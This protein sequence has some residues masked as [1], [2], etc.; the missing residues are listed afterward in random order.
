MYSKACAIALTLVLPATASP[1]VEGLG[2]R[3][4][5]QK[6][7][8]LADSRGIFDYA[9][10]VRQVVHDHNKHRS[11]LQNV[12]R[13]VGRDAF[14][15]GA[16]IKSLMELP[17][18]ALERRQSEGLND[19]DHDEFWAGNIAV[20]TPA[21]PFYIDFDTGSSDLW[22]PS[23]KCTQS[24]CSN[25]HK[26]NLSVSSTGKQTDRQFS[27]H[28][29][30]GSA[31]SGP[32]FTDTVGFA[33]LTVKDQY[34][35]A[36]T[37][38]SDSFGSQAN[39]GILGLGYPLLSN[40][41]KPPFVNSAKAQGVIRQAAFGFKLSKVGSELYIGGTDK[42]QYTGDVEYHNVVGNTGYW[43]IGGGQ[44]TIGSKI[45]STGIKTVIDSGTT[46]IYGPP[47][48]VAKLY[49]SI[50]GSSMHGAN[51]GFYSFPCDKVPSN[52]AFSWGGKQWTI[53]AENFNAGQKS[54]LEFTCLGAI[55]A[56]DLGL[57]DNVWLVG[58][59]FMKNVY[60]AFSF[61]NNAVGFAT[62]K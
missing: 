17:T 3:V 6:R 20:G 38:L 46:L 57:G 12:E 48:A 2:I 59:S 28:Y 15:E 30:D 47:D 27:I 34:F 24:A 10:A 35:S 32:V 16:D 52:V 41:Q 43:Q 33:G 60:S 19:E 44:L 40:I 13:H 4:P 54:L 39:D 62:L 31:V 11:N 42:T 7:S 51:T 29:G 36:A 21:Q 1:V 45:V 22:F 56:K 26:Y 9:K 5:F 50:P 18:H 23:T 61:E 14:N 8:A 49:A 25:K 55:V 37:T 53:S 58:D